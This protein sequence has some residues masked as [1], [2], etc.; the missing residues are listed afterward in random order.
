MPLARSPLPRAVGGTIGVLALVAIVVTGLFGS[1]NP[2]INPSEYLTWI[3]F[4]A[5]L[6]IVSGLVGN[7]WFL[8]N[9][10]AAIYDLV[11]RFVKRGPVWKLPSTGLWPAAA[12]YFAFACL[13]LTSGMANRPWVVAVM[14]IAYSLVT[15][16]GMIFFGRD[17][18]LEHCEAFTVLF[19]IVGRFGPIEAERDTTGA[20]IAVYLRPWGV[21][22]L[23]PAPSGWDRVFFVILM[24]STLAFD[25]ILGTPAWQDFN[26]TL[27]P[28]WLP[29]GSLGF[30]FG[31]DTAHDCFPAH[32][33][34][35]HGDG[36]LL[37]QSEGRPGGDRHRVRFHPGPDRAR[38]QRS[39]QLQLR[40]AAVASP[41]PAAQ[42]SAPEGMEP[43]ACGR[44]AP[45]QL[46]AGAGID[47]LVR[48]DRSDRAGSC[49]RSVPLTPESG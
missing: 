44:G 35:V 37:R 4:W 27:E 45:A 30:F 28:I 34:R 11:T 31:P 26:V 36:H 46:R 41:D 2:A 18:W 48:A 25:G 23:R 17:E 47:D 33:H 42:R 9:P 10:F 29:M 13:E 6:V 19:G 3:Y 5:G 15:L 1:T 14:A 8:L 32:L 22:L 21:G 39:P 7:L 16:S 24:L 20:V 40:R 12:A 43:V 38:L 49:D